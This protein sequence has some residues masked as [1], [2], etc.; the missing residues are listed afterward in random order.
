MCN[1]SS[2]R[3]FEVKAKCSEREEREESGFKIPTQSNKLK[4]RLKYCNS[5]DVPNTIF[6]YRNLVAEIKSW[7]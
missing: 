1:V 7:L 3:Q 2:K 6:K 5:N 4:S